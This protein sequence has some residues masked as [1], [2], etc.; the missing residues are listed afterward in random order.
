MSQCISYY[1]NFYF[2]LGTWYI[3]QS[4]LCELFAKRYDA[5]SAKYDVLRIKYDVP[6]AIWCEPSTMSMHDAPGAMQLI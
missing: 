4:D 6:S 2:I 5:P 3:V 1:L